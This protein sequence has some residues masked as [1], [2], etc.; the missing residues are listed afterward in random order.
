MSA[1]NNRQPAPGAAFADN[2]ATVNG[3][4]TAARLCSATLLLC[5]LCG[6]AVGPNFHR[7]QAPAVTH[8]S[9]AEDPAATAS[10][11]GTAQQF[12]PGAAVAAD[13]WALFQSP[14]LDAVIREAIGNNPG[15]AAAAANLRAS[16]NDLRSGYGI[17]YPTINADANASRERFAPAS[18]GERTP[19][20]VFNLFTLSASVS[21][22]LDV[23][24]GQRRLVEGLRAEVDVAHANE[25]ATYLA[26]AANVVNTVVAAAAYRAEIEATQQLI[27][28]QTE[29]VGIA[30]VQAEAGTV[31]YAN[32]L[33][34]QSQLASYEATIPQL[35]QKLDQSEDLLAALAG[36]PPAEWLADAPRAPPVSL[37][38]LT[39]PSTLPVSLSSDLVRQRP[40]ILAAEATAHAASANIGVATAALLPS[41][42]LNGSYEALTNTTASLFP[43]NGRAWSVGAS[44]TAP[45][46]E[47][48]TLWF[49]RKAAINQYDQAMALY[50]QTVLGAFEQVADALH[51]LD[52]DAATLLAQDEALAAAAEALHLVHIDYEA[53]IATYL[54]VLLADTQFHQA[55]IADLQAIALRYQDTVALFAALGGGWWNERLN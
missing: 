49:K 32:V 40:D 23:F 18:F 51:A 35:K 3:V 27:E 13:W 16:Q 19:S 14:Q 11:Q 25:R 12:N 8:Y 2:G 48:G 53:G 37:A 55:K 39:L 52:H 1:R 28:L 17:F 9:H 30:K 6:C 21:Y 5:V 41:I 24:G 50:R 10:A 4:G 38:D 20:S 33:S 36:H 45:L 29:Q 15:L 22:A 43:P 7:P 47:G 44:A 42:T 26:L 54:D 46:F 34:L 31:P